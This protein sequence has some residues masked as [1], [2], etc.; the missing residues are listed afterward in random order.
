MNKEKVCAECGKPTDG[1]VKIRDSYY[2]EQ[3]L[4]SGE[5]WDAYD[6][7]YCDRCELLHDWDTNKTDLTWDDYCAE[8]DPIKEKV[9]I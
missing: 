9:G 6:G 4:C 2:G 3:S 1:T 7:Y 5:C 8:S